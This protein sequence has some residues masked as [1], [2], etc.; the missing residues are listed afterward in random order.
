MRSIFVN[1][2]EKGYYGEMGSSTRLQETL[3]RNCESTVRMTHQ[4]ADE[5]KLTKT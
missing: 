5:S 4:Q 1:G 3:G 2:E